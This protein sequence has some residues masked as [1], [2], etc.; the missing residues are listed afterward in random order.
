MKPVTNFIGRNLSNACYTRKRKYQTDRRLGIEGA[1][2]HGIEDQN[3][4]R[5]LVLHQEDV[6]D[7]LLPVEAEKADPNHLLHHLLHLHHQEEIQTT[8]T[9]KET[10]SLRT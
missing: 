1:D 3:H 5:H 7:P 4:S 9:R 2:Q 10:I 8:T 6:E